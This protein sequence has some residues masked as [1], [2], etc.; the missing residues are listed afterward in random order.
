MTSSSASSHNARRYRRVDLVA[1]RDDPIEAFARPRELP[2]VETQVAE[3]FVV[4]DRRVVDDQ[5]FELLDALAAWKHLEGAADEPDVGGDF[6]D[7]VDERAEP[8]ADEDDPEPV[9][10]RPAAREVQE[11]DG[12]QDDAVGVEEPEHA[13]A[14]L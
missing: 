4:A 6:D 12:L 10:V 13:G 5:P 9:H 1:S 2:V 8:A 11:R 3:L 7:D 14:R